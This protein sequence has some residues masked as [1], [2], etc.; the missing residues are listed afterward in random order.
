LA[1]K[2]DDGRGRLRKVRG[3]CQTNVDPGKTTIFTVIITI[4]QLLT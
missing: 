2:D 3:S 4:I 1:S